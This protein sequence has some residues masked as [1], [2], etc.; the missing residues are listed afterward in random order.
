MSRAGGVNHP[1]FRLYYK[2]IVIKTIWE[3]Y[4][5]LGKIEGRRREHQRMRWLDGFTNAMGIKLGKLCEMVRDREAWCVVV[6]G[7][8]KWMTEQHIDLPGGSHDKESALSAG[9]L[10]SIPG[11]GRSSEEGNGSPL[12]YSCLENPMNRGV[13]KTIVHV[14]TKSQT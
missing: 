7:V 1:D 4:L 3:K 6:H 9:N 10:G 8:A 13:W 5:M 14:V 12:Q 11:L 2:D